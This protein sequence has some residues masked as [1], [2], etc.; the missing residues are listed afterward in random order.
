LLHD[1]WLS[2]ATTLRGWAHQTGWDELR[3]ARLR[4]RDGTPTDE[5]PMLL[6]E[7][8]DDIPGDLP[9]QVEVKAHGDPE[10]AR[11]T[12]AVVCRVAGTPL[13]AAV[14][15]F[16]LS[17][18]SRA[19]R[20]RATEF[21]PGWWRGPTMRPRRS[22]G[23]RRAHGSAASA[24]SISSC[25]PRWSIAYGVVA[26][27]SRPGRSTTRRWPCERLPSGSTRS[28]LIDRR[29]CATSSLRCRWRPK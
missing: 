20:P 29:R 12:A 2:S 14:W 17:I 19:R 1:P 9:V 10:L 23:G 27:A 4:D 8:L 5:T 25:T 13:T 22:R 15:R 11:A 28:P 16:S 21:R 3:N 26:S 7:L 24:S 18:R 6:D